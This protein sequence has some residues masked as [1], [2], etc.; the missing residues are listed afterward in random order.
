MSAL[1]EAVHELTRDPKVF[2][3][4][5]NGTREIVEERSLLNLLN[6]AKTM[7][8]NTGGGGAAGGSKLP[9]SI[10]P[11]DIEADIIRTIHE[12]I[13]VH[14]RYEAARLP[15]PERIQWWAG[16]VEE[17]LALNHVTYWSECIRELF[18]RRFHLDGACPECGVAK[19]ANE[20]EGEVTWKDTLMVTVETETAGCANCGAVWSGVDELRNLN[21]HM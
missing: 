2:I 6:D 3:T 5:D 15:L 13:G 7:K 1:T 8:L 21:D 9:F 19:V 17:S 12:T 18:R 10:G 14:N 20:D 16:L 11:T 4:R